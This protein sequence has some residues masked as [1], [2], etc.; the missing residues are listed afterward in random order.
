VLRQAG[1]DAITAASAKDALDQTAVQR[2]DAAILDL[3]RQVPG[4]HR[5]ERLIRAGA[6]LG[7]WRGSSRC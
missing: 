1:F 7:E 4:G 6:K 3:L 5:H 2:P